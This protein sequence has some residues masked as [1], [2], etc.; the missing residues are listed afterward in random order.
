M[1]SENALPTVCQALFEV[2]MEGLYV[3]LL[4]VAFLALVGGLVVLAQL[5]EVLACGWHWATKRLGVRK[6]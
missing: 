3:P 4:G 1:P 5:V 2:W 6:R